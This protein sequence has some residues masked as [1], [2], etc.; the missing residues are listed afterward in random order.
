MPYDIGVYVGNF[1]P[2]GLGLIPSSGRWLAAHTDVHTFF[3]W[4]VNGCQFHLGQHKISDWP[5]QLTV[6][7]LMQVFPEV[8]VF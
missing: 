2:T 4:L 1:Q 5:R 7:N 6:G 8:L 3:G